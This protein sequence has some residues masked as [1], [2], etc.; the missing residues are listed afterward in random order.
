LFLDIDPEEGI[1]AGSRWESVLYSKLVEARAVIALHSENWKASRWCFAE[2]SHAKLLGRTV[3][4]VVIDASPLDSSL[5]D[6]QGINLADPQAIE[7]LVAGLR[8]AGIEVR[9]SGSWEGSRSP[10]PGLGAFSAEDAAVFF[11]RENETYRI[12][13][14]LALL[15]HVGNH[16]FVLLTG[17]SGC[18]KSSLMLAGVLPRLLA[19]K[20]NW[21]VLPVFRPGRDP[22]A[23]LQRHIL[24]TASG[25]SERDFELNATAG[26]TII[27]VI[28]QVEEALTQSDSQNAVEFLRA[29]AATLDHSSAS[30]LAVGTIRTDSLPEF[31]KTAKQ[32]GLHYDCLPVST[33]DKHDLLSTVEGPAELDGIWLQPGLSQLM[34]EDCGDSR[35]LP[36]L[37]YTLREMYERTRPPRRFTHDL[38]KNQL[39]GVQG[40]L[41][42]TIDAALTGDSVTKPSPE[43]LRRVFF[44]LVRL[45]DSGE[46]VRRR[47]YIDEL[48]A[49]AIELV[50]RLVPARIL[51]K[52]SEGARATVEVAHEAIFRQWEQLSQWLKD[53][54][55]YFE[56]ER[57]FQN[58][59]TDWRVNGTTLSLGGLQELLKWK[60]LG[61]VEFDNTTEA[62]LTASRSNTRFVQT[63]RK[64]FAAARISVSLS[65]C[66]LLGSVALRYIL[67]DSIS[68]G[69]EEVRPSAFVNAAWFCLVFGIIGYI[70]GVLSLGFKPAAGL[71]S[72]TAF[73]LI[74]LSAGFASV[75]LGGP[76]YWSAQLLRSIPLTVAFAIAFVS[77]GVVRWRT[78]RPS[79]WAVALILSLSLLPLQTWWSVRAEAPGLVEEPLFD[80]IM[81]LFPQIAASIGLPESVPII[82]GLVAVG[83]SMAVL[84]PL[85]VD[86]TER[87]TPA[88]RGQ[89][90]SFS[91][92][93]WSFVGA[94]VVVASAA[95]ALGKF[96]DWSSTRAAD[97]DHARGVAEQ[98]IAWQEG[99]FEAKG[100]F[101]NSLGEISEAKSKAKTEFDELC[102]ASKADPPDKRDNALAASSKR[103]EKFQHFGKDEP[104][105]VEIRHSD[106][107]GWAGIVLGPS[108]QAGCTVWQ[109]EVSRE[110]RMTLGRQLSEEPEVLCDEV[111]EPGVRTSYAPNEIPNEVRMSDPL[112]MC[113]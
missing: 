3:I 87:N 30:I 61:L 89:W 23:Q 108:K 97:V 101:A 39:G 90:L 67:Q 48:P 27:I 52:D 88:A 33:M 113:W 94:V 71:S 93:E 65:L 70:A 10:F 28:D 104:A 63:A 18:G 25:S 37:A 98:L 111:F 40:S 99:Y 110:V 59:L 43:L 38:Y 6:I 12:V 80:S 17:S 15:R 16:Q 20:S 29:I 83:L 68:T 107:N 22:L 78:L 54:R 77:F 41:S 74:G 86:Q 36:L 82:V 31:E 5:T 2:I 42:R 8:A 81:R 19:D 76:I 69:Y 64:I 62:L 50:D 60:R 21:H 100:R 32:A 34:V 47:V 58:A 92:F 56:W 112:P 49:E 7:R 96:I 106:K 66:W 44:R 84:G 73:L 11:G 14:R 53:H 45:S 95:L 35:A 4:P 26:A 75:W 85:P 46:F 79:W 9:S 109:G 55:S 105:I 91:E 72:A 51:I 103:I 57:R 24:P 13:D 1:N 102:R